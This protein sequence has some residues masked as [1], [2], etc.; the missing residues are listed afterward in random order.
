M[1]VS[2]I[3]ITGAFGQNLSVGEGPEKL[4]PAYVDLLDAGACAS[5]W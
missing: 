1:T 5:W 3:L 2:T 4:I